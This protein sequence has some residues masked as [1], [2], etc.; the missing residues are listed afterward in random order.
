MCHMFYIIQLTIFDKEHIFASKL[1]N[2][3]IYYHNGI[4]I[5]VSNNKLV[6]PDVLNSYV[7]VLESG[8]EDAPN[9]DL[10][11]VGRKP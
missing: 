11:I 9:I 2:L 1:I 4:I 6:L 10:Q 3:S 8:E 7:L 5:V